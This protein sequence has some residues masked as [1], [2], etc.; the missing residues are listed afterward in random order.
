MRSTWLL[1]LVALALGTGSTV[2][3]P[4]G[5]QSMATAAFGIGVVIDYGNGTVR[6]YD[7]VTADNVLSATMTVADVEVAW[8]GNLAFVTAIDG[9]A[10]DGDRDL[11]WQYWVNGDYASVAANKYSLNDSDTIEWV[12]GP[13]QQGTQPTG[14]GS[15]P[16]PMLLWYAIGTVAAGGIVLAGYYLNRRKTLS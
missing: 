2:H 4:I 13:S 3:G 7:N 15:S 8:Y 10:N 1:C 9:V 12:R 16:D 14:T 6:S 5:Q 11:W